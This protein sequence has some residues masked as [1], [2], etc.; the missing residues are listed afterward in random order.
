MLINY[1]KIMP[2]Q[3]EKQDHPKWWEYKFPKW[4][5]YVLLIILLILIFGI[6]KFVF[7]TPCCKNDLGN[8]SVEETV[9]T[10]TDQ[11]ADWKTYRNE[12]YG[13]EFKYPAD[14][15][16]RSA[17]VNTQ[18]QPPKVATDGSWSFEPFIEIGNPMSGMNVYPLYIFISLNQKNLSAESY[19]K[20][21]IADA[22]KEGPGGIKYDREFTLSVGDLQ[23]YELYGVFAYDQNDEEIT[24]SNK[25]FAYTIKFPVPDENP[26]LSNPKDNNVIAHQ[27][28]STFK[29]VSTSTPLN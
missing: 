6:I 14:W 15:Q 11:F 18:N 12:E 3:F 17:L 22:P 9:S 25:N 1:F 5:N 2:P 16:F 23:A 21:M 4:M 28:L 29:F 27:I 26:N 24:L 7:T 20:D 8:N 10:T 19:V 13:F